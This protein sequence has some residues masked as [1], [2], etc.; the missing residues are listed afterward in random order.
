MR[1]PNLAAYRKEVK[2]LDE[3]HIKL[4]YQDRLKEVDE[5]DKHESIEQK[6]VCLV[7]CLVRR[8]Y[9]ILP[10]FYSST[11]KTGIR[12]PDDGRP[13][14]EVETDRESVEGELEDRPMEALISRPKRRLYQ[15][16]RRQ[17]QHASRARRR[18]RTAL[19]EGR[20]KLNTDAR[21][22]IDLNDLGVALGKTWPIHPSLQIVKDLLQRIRDGR[23]AEGSLLTLDTEFI[24]FTRRVLEVAVGEVHA[25]KVLIDVRVDHQCS[26]EDLLK[27][28]DGRLMGLKEQ[29]IS[30]Q[31]L[32][33]V[34]GSTDSEKCSGKKTAREIAEMLKSAGVSQKSIILVWHV[35]RFDLTVLRELLESKGYTDILPPQGNC[36]PMIK[37]YPSGIAPKR[38]DWQSL[39]HEKIYA[40]F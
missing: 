18:L 10:M 38:Q 21:T 19:M 26:T 30:F 8:T 9:G 2:A 28:P 16:K 1:H 24:S 6:R 40:E 7:N 12:Y 27:M 33:Q 34:Y 31:S 15:K 14:P 29:R 36:I 3:S 17:T 13:G 20:K 23:E 32:R 4:A 5:I 35:N 37:H 39:K 22:F 25:G 11:T